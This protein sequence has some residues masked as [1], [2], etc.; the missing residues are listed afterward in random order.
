MQPPG[1]SA[2]DTTAKQINQHVEFTPFVS[3]ILGETLYNLDCFFFQLKTPVSL[4]SFKVL[5]MTLNPFSETHPDTIPDINMCNLNPLSSN[6][7]RADG[8]PT[9]A[10]YYQLV[11]N[12]TVCS[13]C[14]ETEREAMEQLK[15]DLMT[16]SGYYR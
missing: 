2:L 8:L 5:E 3:Y 6:H 11:G 15:M 13:G 4:I 12:E 14:N 9:L 16:V 1:Q 7:S 10:K